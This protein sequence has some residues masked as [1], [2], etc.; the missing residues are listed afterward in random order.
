MSFN[1]YS[2]YYHSLLSS[3]QWQLKMGA[4]RHEKG[5]TEF[6]VW[7]PNAKSMSLIVF[8]RGNELR[9]P[10]QKHEND[11]YEAS[12]PDIAPNA[13]Y[14]YAIN[15]EQ[16]RP[17]PVSRWQP[18]GVHGPSRI[19]DPMSFTWHDQAW[20]GI[21]LQDYIIYELHIGTF[22]PAGTF[23]AVIAKLPYLKSLGI[24]AIELMPVIE[25]PGQRNWGYDGTHPYAPHHAYGG[26]DG[27]KRLINAAHQTGLAVIIDVVYNHLGPEGNYLGEYG[28]YF[29]DHYK[30]PWGQAI[31]FDG[32]YSDSVRQYFV[33]NALYWLIE[34]HVDALRLDAVHAIY[35]FSAYHILQEL[36]TAF[37]AHEDTLGRQVYII[38][39][40]DLNDVRII[41][42]VE[43]GGYA[44]DAQWSDDFHHA[45]HALLTKSKK[46]Y[47][48]DFGKISQLSKALTEGFVYDRQWSKFRQKR[49]G[50]SSAE[51]PGEKFVVCLQNHDQIGNALLGQ[52]IGTV[53]K[54]N[55]Y[56]LGSTIL[57]CAPNLP[58]LFMGQE[59]NAS[60][61]F[62]FFTSFEDEE[63]ANN[64]REGYK[65]EFHLHGPESDSI[66]PQNPSRFFQS[67][68]QWMQLEESDHKNMH[69]FYQ[70]LIHLR[71]ELP[72]LSNCRKDLT[73][74]FFNEGEQFLIIERGDPSGQTA[75]LIANF[76]D[77]PQQI[78]IPFPAGNWSMIF[79]SSSD[80]TKAPPSLV[81]TFSNQEGEIKSL[82]VPAWTALLYL[83][84]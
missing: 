76:A 66:D 61:P 29:T 77:H 79:C 14:F 6:R 84:G 50:S 72:C 2:E 35:D 46:R 44:I 33:D 54:P 16:Q 64:V 69:L 75:F 23:D 32:P 47:F 60:T 15:G 4:N 10:M 42:P 31:N 24:T 43:K 70:K 49:F 17:D 18:Y 1:P 7:A 62:F 28:Y 82:P 83:A 67:K 80:D 81:A 53:I 40:S 65:K 37:H 57:F 34:Y 19:Y 68:L 20:R 39:E 73:K 56:K 30:T 5:T 8:D 22:T 21:K 3:F 48:F 9:F 55:Q 38:A 71:K 12:L 52:R 26:P 74:T 45:L 36:R 13:D 78:E 41:N 11:V 25:F 27:L 51:C 58:L 59:W 63:L